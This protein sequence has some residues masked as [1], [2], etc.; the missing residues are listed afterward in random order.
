MSDMHR[1]ESTEPREDVPRPRGAD[2]VDEDTRGEAHTRPEGLGFVVPPPAKLSPMKIVGIA[3]AFFGVL[4]AAFVW[5][6][7]P[8]RHARAA[9]EADAQEAGAV[10][11]RVDVVTPSVVSS[12]KALVLPATVQ[13]LEDT[14]LYARAS[15]YVRKWNVDIG[16]KV[17]EGQVLAEIDTPDLDQEIEQARSQLAQAQAGLAQAK[18]SHD[19]A[20]VNL[21]RAEKLA[22]AGVSSQQDLDQRRGQAKVDDASVLV[23]QA[24]V[25]SA[26][27]NVHKLDQLKSFAK[28][29]APFAGTITERI[30]QRG[31][32][33]T[34][35]SQ[36]PLFHLAS[37]DP[38]RVLLGVP[39]DVAPSVKVDA[40]AS[41]SVREYPGQKFEGKV[42][43]VAG[44]LDA[45]SRTMNVEVR[46]PNPDNK[47]LTGMFA[48]VSLSLP[49]PHRVFEVP[50]TALYNDAKGLRLATVG[51]G[52]EVHYV[53]VTL[54]RDTGATILLSTG[55]EGS[56]RVIKVANASLVEGAHVV[57]R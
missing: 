24:A 48:Q 23:A 53:P 41:V 40:A 43:R 12:D 7:L 1:D 20:A 21:V 16:D 14:I 31:Q 44:A 37:L 13:P 45:T 32:L 39:Q 56:E 38:V 15:G 22:A 27:A 25:A 51:V 8:R 9:L 3:V 6:Y 26:Q 55:L 34:A 35:G 57:V 46:V 54:E 19:L 18:A 52:D 11:V 29:T 36:N 49:L 10:G 30:V 50:A 5:G 42:S 2:G 17:T 33:V 28:V 4:G 47:L